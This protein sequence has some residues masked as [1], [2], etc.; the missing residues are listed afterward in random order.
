M[1]PNMKLEY[2]LIGMDIPQFAILKDEIFDHPLQIENGINY[3]TSDPLKAI[4]CS[5]QAVYSDGDEMVMKMTMDLAFELSE[6]SWQ[7]LRGDNGDTII[8]K[9]FLWHL[10]TLTIGAAR[11]ALFVSTKN[12]NLNSLSLPLVDLTTI[13]NNDMVIKGKRV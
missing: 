9:D 10:G 12:T 2:K 4:K 1:L 8:P 11:G 3:S 7:S 6:A 13:I 5:F